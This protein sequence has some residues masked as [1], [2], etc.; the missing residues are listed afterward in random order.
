M[1]W[2]WEGGRGKGSL[3]I[4]TRKADVSPTMTFKDITI[5]SRKFPPSGAFPSVPRQSRP[6]Q[7]AKCKSPCGLAMASGTMSHCG[8]GGVRRGRPHATLSAASPRKARQ[9]KAR[10]G[11]ARQGKTHVGVCGL[12]GRRGWADNSA[13]QRELFSRAV[14]ELSVQARRKF[15]TA[16]AP[17]KGGKFVPSRHA[18]TKDMRGWTGA[19][20]YWTAGPVSLNRIVPRAAAGLIVRSVG[21]KPIVCLSTHSVGSIQRACGRGHK[22]PRSSLSIGPHNEWRLTRASG[23]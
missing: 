9:G 22:L 21:F 12:G 11:K 16:A 15:P 4:D 10:Q 14:L 18:G 17:N 1:G 7:G 2:R 23:A 19:V 8:C 5:P 13:F 6:A 3:I 20:Y